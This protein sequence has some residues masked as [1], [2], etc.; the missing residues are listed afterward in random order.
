MTGP[1]P[2]DREIAAAVVETKRRLSIVW[3]IPFVALA[4]GAFVAWRTYSERGPAIT[5]TLATAEGLEAG[6]TKIKYK[7]VEVGLVETVTL[8]ENFSDVVVQARMAKQ[9]TRYLTDRT[10][11]WVVK[12]RVAGGQVSGL[13]T[14]FSGAYIG[15]DPVAEG[16]STRQFRALDVAPVVTTDDPGKRFVLHSYGAGAVAV[17]TPLFFRK[18][19]VG[20]VL[21]S[22]LDPSGDFVVIEV[23]VDAPHDERVHESTRFWNA[24]GVDLS[25]SAEGVRFDTES[26]VSML[27]GGIAF[28]THGSDHGPP[29]PADAVFP[30]YEN[31]DATQRE[32]YT[33]K[34]EWLLYF[35]QS[36]RGLSP[37]AP[38]ELLGIRI[39]QVRDVKL[40]ADP[41]QRSFRTPVRIEIEPE[42]IHNL[43]LPG[44]SRR[45]RM[46]ALVARG[47][48]A[49]LKSG[50]L[51]TG[52]LV[53]AL[54]IHEDAPPATIAWDQ[55][56]PVFPTVPTP[57]EEITQSLTELAKKLGN[58]P[59]DQMTQDLQRTLA[60]TQAALVEAK[61][62]LAA[63][64]EMVGPESAVQVELQRALYELSDALRSLGL[65]AEQI[66]S[67]PES[68][69]F[70]KGKD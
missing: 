15:M 21:S 68:V 19:E 43:T 18:I 57:I 50:N 44:A 33:E 39:G 53:V 12:A 10:R 49:Q 60:T 46:D 27:I 63:T 22:R 37:G 24:S 48:R 45:E 65:A 9:T 13:G 31:R 1:E 40:E 69:L 34:V 38:V 41:E 56:V 55:P 3:L 66:E 36:V 6:K 32:M 67:Q 17:G 54:D 20:R 62:T 2:A 8:G 29:A 42:R 70:G 64:R 16:A 52:Q 14:L 30:L 7:D 28:D 58:L 51:L 59:L 4:I 61:E 5:I 23:F 35:D 26:V 25:L 47:L 11:F